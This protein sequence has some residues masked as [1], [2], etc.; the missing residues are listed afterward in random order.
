M[1]EFSIY[2]WLIVLL[3]VVLLFGSRKIPEL[4]GGLGQSF[5]SFKEGMAGKSS[6]AKLPTPTNREVD[7]KTPDGKA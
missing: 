5:R 2:H 4:M 1:G 7:G 6:R 3:I